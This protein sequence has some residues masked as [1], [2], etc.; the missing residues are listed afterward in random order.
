MPSARSA[1]AAGD[2]AEVCL[3]VCVGSAATHRVL[4]VEP[5]GLVEQSE[6]L[7]PVAG[8]HGLLGPIDALLR[9]LGVHADGH[10]ELFSRD[11]QRRLLQGVET[12]L[13]ESA[14]VGCAVCA[15]WLRLEPQTWPL[16][17]LAAPRHSL[18]LQHTAFVS[19]MVSARRPAVAY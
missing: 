11:A 10:D 2:E 6:R 9:G 4:W 16:V 12:L 19:A 13:V 1:A 17:L 14:P 7:V 15:R 3:R 8:G 5:N 18:Q